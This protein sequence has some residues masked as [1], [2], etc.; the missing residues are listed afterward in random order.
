V[1]LLD[2]NRAHVVR[3]AESRNYAAAFDTLLARMGFPAANPLSAI[4]RPGQR[5]VIKPNLVFHRH[6]RGGPLEAVI[7]APGLIRAVCD[8]V[9]EAVGR[10]GEV[11]VGDAPLQSCDWERLTSE[12]G[13]DR[14]PEEYAR[15][16]YW[17]TLADFRKFASTDLR[18]LKHSPVERRGDPAGY[19]PVDLG[20]DSMHAGRDWKRYRVTNYDPAAMTSHHNSTRHEYLIS[21]SVLGCGALISLPKLKTHR[22]SGLTC[23]L[24]NLIGINGSKD[25]LPH[26]SAGGTAE[27]GDEFPGKPVWKKLASWIVSKEEGVPGLGSKAALNAARRL[28]YTTGA[29]LTGDGRSEGS[30]T[31]NDTLWRTIVDLNRIA[32][33]ADK[34]GVLQREP[35]RTILTIVDAVVAG[36]GEGPMAPDP[37]ELGCLVGGLNPVAVEVAAT[38]LAGWPEEQLRHLTG[39]FGLERYPLTNFARQRI[40]VDAYPAQLSQLARRLRPT[41]GFAEMFAETE[42]RA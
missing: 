25:W 8:R 10:E 26:H 15:Q 39:A 31:G 9:F 29:L 34:Q 2:S 5:V 3:S 24:K 19:R 27:G 41:P 4:L 7:T 22:K 6:Y 38:R 30:W 13:L 28:V 14:W 17:L 12:T 18:G 35:Q 20:A 42:A 40:E 1:G 21:G 37:V 16:G 23:A 11:T 33:Y 36:E 32:Y